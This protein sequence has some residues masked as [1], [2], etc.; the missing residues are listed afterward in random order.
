MS[1]YFD[2]KLLPILQKLAIAEEDFIAAKE[3]LAEFTLAW[4]T[5]V[6]S[7][8]IYVSELN[9]TTLEMTR[10]LPM[11]DKLVDLSAEELRVLHAELPP[12]P[13]RHAAAIIIEQIQGRDR[14]RLH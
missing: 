3:I 13:L 12:S 1:I 8:D 11:S 14:P 4:T 10:L 6:R 5:Q 7:A 2:P 9:D